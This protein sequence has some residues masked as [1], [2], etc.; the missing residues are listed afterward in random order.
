MKK[1][2]NNILGFISILLVVV[3][4]AL[5]L[6]NLGGNPP[7]LNWDEVSHGVNAKSILISGKD[8][9]GL[10]MPNIFRAFGDYKLPVYIYLTTLFVGVAGLSEFSVRIVS[11]LSG[12]ITCLFVYLIAKK[13]FSSRRIAL[14]AGITALALPWGVFLSRVAL[15]ANLSLALVVAGVYGAFYTERKITKN[16]GL[17]A[18]A[19]ALHTYNSA[20]VVVPFL[21][22]FVLLYYFLQKRIRSILPGVAVVAFSLA[23]VGIQIYGGTGLSR[24]EKLSLLSENNVYM[25]G[26]MR[27]KSTLPPPLSRLVYN[28]PTYMAYRIVGNYK[29]YF[30]LGFLTQS[31]G[32]QAQFAIPNQNLILWTNT[33]LMI[34]G[35]AYL[36]LTNYKKAVLVFLMLILVFLPAAVTESS[37]QALRPLYAIPVVV[38]LITYGYKALMNITKSNK[39]AAVGLVITLM[40]LEFGGY[41]YKY[42]NVYSKKYSTAWQYGYKQVVEKTKTL[43]PQYDRVIVTKFYGEPHIFFAFW[44]AYPVTSLIPS[45]NNVRFKQSEWYWTDKVEK[46]YFVNDWEINKDGKSVK[47]ESGLMLPLQKSLLVTSA[48]NVFADS[49]VIDTV[50]DPEGKIVFLI[51]TYE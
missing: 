7:S 45:E 41:Y 44:G 32:A 24:Y 51:S 31:E 39:K 9:W 14:L 28:R 26:Q 43:A 8:E 35:S 20:R 19:L 50:Y 25:I 33:A 40:L 4:I 42:T 23:L 47:T 2:S 13:E 27:S 36:L 11:A 15:E 3:I 22:L 17:V 21:I 34:I 30:S 6:W 10:Q 38:L 1:K 18:L 46:Y 37:P 16:L 29:N 49:K 48:G 12:L 5:R